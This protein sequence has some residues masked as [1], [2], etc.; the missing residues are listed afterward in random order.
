MHGYQCSWTVMFGSALLLLLGKRA[1]SKDFPCR[2]D[3]S[4]GP[5]GLWVFAVFVMVAWFRR[6]L[7]RAS[8][9]RHLTKSKVGKESG[10][11]GR[12]GGCCL[13]RNV[14]MQCFDWL[15]LIGEG[16]L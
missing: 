2:I 9:R 6:V 15:P 11:K 4:I 16:F 8:S 1:E 12:H 13:R 10:S 5:F 7:R 3:K 14:R